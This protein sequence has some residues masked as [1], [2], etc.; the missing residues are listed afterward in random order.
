MVAGLVRAALL[1]VVPVL[2]AG[3]ADAAMML[4]MDVNSATVSADG[5]FAGVNHTG[6]LTFG[7][8]SE[9]TTLFD[10]L[11]DDATTGASPVTA[12]VSGMIQLVD[13][14]VDG[15]FI[16]VEAFDA[17]MMSLGVFTTEI[18]PGAGQVTEQAFVGYKI[19]GLLAGGSFDS[20]SF[21]GV[22]VTEWRANEPLDGSFLTFAYN[23]DAMG[24]DSAVD[25]DLWVNVPAPG[26]VA[27]FG[28]GGIVALKRRRS[29]G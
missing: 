21:N 24:V 26:A 4:Q 27:L 17:G 22:D 20:D 12:S 3:S 16:T 5:A 29:I 23:P 1:G 25:L 10:I 6:A 13:G 14:Q 18:L 9:V 8:T 2:A 15:G 28:L 19:D 7:W 11:I